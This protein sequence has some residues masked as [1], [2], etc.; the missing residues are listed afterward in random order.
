MLTCFQANKEIDKVNAKIKGAAAK[1]GKK[2]DS[3]MGKKAN[4]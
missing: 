2:C 1:L 3:L 4:P